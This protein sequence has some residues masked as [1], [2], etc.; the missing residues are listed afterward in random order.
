MEN[1]NINRVRKKKV[2]Y[3][4]SYWHNIDV[5]KYF[6]VTQIWR[7][8]GFNAPR[9]RF[10][11]DNEWFPTGA[12]MIGTDGLDSHQ[13]LL[14]NPA[15]QNHPSCSCEE[16]QEPSAGLVPLSGSSTQLAE[17]RVVSRCFIESTRSTLKRLI[18]LCFLNY[19]SK[20]TF[21][22]RFFLGGRLGFHCGAPWG[23]GG[24][25]SSLST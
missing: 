7:Q 3:L 18:I 14:S 1:E 11:R 21:P 16:T 24:S 20:Q 4:T 12:W 17:R 10:Y 5:L 25:T 6:N 19:K 23:R 13:P 9:G 22:P 8:L 2:E 15:A